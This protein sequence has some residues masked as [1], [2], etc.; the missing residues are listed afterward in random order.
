MVNLV[1][2][3]RDMTE[4]ADLVAYTAAY[5]LGVIEVFWLY[6]FLLYLFTYKWLL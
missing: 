4:G 3:I 1:K 2:D 5:H 6:I